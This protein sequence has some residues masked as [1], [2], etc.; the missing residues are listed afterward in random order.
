M[1]QRARR[2]TRAARR[3]VYTEQDSDGADDGRVRKRKAE[4]TDDTTKG[5]KARPRK[6]TL[7]SA[8]SSSLS[9]LNSSPSGSPAGPSAEAQVGLD[10]TSAL[11]LTRHILDAPGRAHP[12]LY[13]TSH[14]LPPNR[15][16]TSVDE[17]APKDL[18]ASLL[19]WFD[20]VKLNRAMPWRKEVVDIESWSE[21]QKGQR[22][23][24]VWVSEIM[25]QQTQVETV[26]SYYLR[27]MSRFPTIFDL[28]KADVEQVNECWQ[29]LGYYSRASRLLSGAKKVVDRFAGVLPQDPSLM[30]KEVD[31]IGPYSAGAIASIAYAKPVPMVDGNV[32][33]VLSRIT[34][35]YAPQAAKATT[36]FLWSTAAQLVPQERPGDF[37]QALMELGAT[38]CKPREANC[39]S[40]PLSQWCRAYQEKQ[41]LCGLDDAPPIPLKKRSSHKDDVDMENVCGL[42]Q[43]L[44]SRS[45]Q[46]DGHV[47][48][49]PMAKERKKA[50]RREVAV[51]LVIWQE[52]P[53]SRSEQD[54][55]LEYASPLST[56]QTQTLVLKRPEKGLLAGLWEF[57]SI[58]L[59]T[60]NDSTGEGRR[61]AVEGILRET[62]EGF[63]EMTEVERGGV[64]LRWL[65][66]LADIEHVFSHLKV[67]YKS[68][69]LV[70][71][72]P[73]PPIL[74]PPALTHSLPLARWSPCHDILSAN[75]GNPHKKVWLAWRQSSSAASSNPPNS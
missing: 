57:P 73:S 64:L 70:I 29:G 31:G 47:L 5:K 52:S 48:I 12:M 19:R 6:K 71:Q 32:H 49:Y 42:C 14:I 61:E 46:S 8:D 45:P 30:E 67:T 13:H 53:S 68:Q 72:S 41:V 3:I 7:Q 27:W 43:P 40:C 74:R 10:G 56:G 54:H 63:P 69:V 15:L 34:A 28:A 4:L 38:L 17:E 39:A 44:E 24:E 23:Y 51:C 33:R 37:N 59:P 66:P 35:L 58:D 25:L 20:Q 65:E 18:Q 50:A 26:K 1:T 22:A 16:E 55:P 2:S 21:Q 11:G 62:I 36:K 60:S 9:D 75:L